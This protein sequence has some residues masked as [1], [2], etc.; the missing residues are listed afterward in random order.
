MDAD[1]GPVVRPY[2]MTGGRVRTTGSFDVIS[3]VTA[4]DGTGVEHALYLQPEHRAIL[5]LTRAPIAV[6]EV[7]SHVDLPLGVVRVL[8]G[9]LLEYQLI[10]VHHP[11]EIND[12]PTDSVLRAVIDGLR[13]I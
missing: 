8:L 9:D 2:A 5:A 12:F 4:R 1:A 13:A 10:T 6:A 3:L 7:A 11:P